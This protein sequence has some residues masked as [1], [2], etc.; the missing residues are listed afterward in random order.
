M[1]QCVLLSFLLCGVPQGSVLGPVRFSSDRPPLGRLFSCFREESHHCYADDPQIY[2][3]VEHENLN[4]LS[5][6]HDHLAATEGW[7]SLLIDPDLSSAVDLY[8]I[9]LFVQSC[10]LQ[11][12]NITSD[13]CRRLQK[14]NY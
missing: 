8:T 6:L 12:R 1:S 5:V 2:S 10:F 13:V 11:L 3:S 9:I 7:M 4:Q 14:L